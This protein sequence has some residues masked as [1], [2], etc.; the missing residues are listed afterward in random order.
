MYDVYLSQEQATALV[1][2]LKEDTNLKVVREI[3]YKLV[4][5]ELYHNEELVS[6]VKETKIN[7]NPTVEELS[8]RISKGIFPYLTRIPLIN[9]ILY[10]TP[11]GLGDARDLAD[12]L[13]ISPEDKLKEI[14]TKIRSHFPEGH[15][16]YNVDP[17]D[18]FTLLKILLDQSAVKDD[19]ID[20][21][22]EYMQTLEEVNIV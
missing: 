12:Y 5:R 19:D 1:S 21:L 3:S 13:C 14:K 8:E 6:P 15:A 9:L 16:L 20:D 2:E 17:N 22:V 10:L 18:L 7:I 4:E 11:V